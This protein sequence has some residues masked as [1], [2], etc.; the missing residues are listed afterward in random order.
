ALDSRITNTSMPL[1]QGASMTILHA[2]GA[3]SVEPNANSLVVR[4]DLGS[5]A[6]LL[7]GDAEA[8]NRA[9]PSTPPASGSVEAELLACCIADLAAQVLV[10]GHHGSKT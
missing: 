3:S 6:V 5:T 10:V 4:L 2:D 8:G 7:M 9:D 1:G